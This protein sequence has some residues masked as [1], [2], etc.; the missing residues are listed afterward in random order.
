LHEIASS[1][2]KSSNKSFDKEWFLCC[3]AEGQQ[4]QVGKNIKWRYTIK[5]TVPLHNPLK[6]GTFIKIIKDAG[7]SKD[8][9]IDL[10]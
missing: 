9:F 5:I 10:L 8:E 6:M 2:R 4:C 1:F 7:L 3:Q